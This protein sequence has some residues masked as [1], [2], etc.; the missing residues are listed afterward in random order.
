[1]NKS[2]RRTLLVAT[3]L[4]SCVVC[5][6]LQSFI[7]QYLENRKARFVSPVGS[8]N[9]LIRL[10]QSHKLHGSVLFMGSSITE[11]LLP[12]ED[13]NS[14]AMSGSCFA[15]S[16]KLLNDPEQF[17][18][19]TVYILETNNLFKGYNTKILKRTEKWDFNLFRDSSHFSLAAKPS[20]LI[21]SVIFHIL[22]QNQVKNAG[23]FETDIAQPVDF[24]NV[25]S[26]SAQELKD[27]EHLIKGVEE[28][29]A[30]GGRLCFVYLPTIQL[31]RYAHCYAPACKL[32]KHLNIPLLHYNTQSWVDKLEYTDY[33]HVNSRAASTVR[34]MNTVAR[35]ARIHAVK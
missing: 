34:F 17:A 31:E 14:I 15:S 13:I 2:R 8:E 3:A 1:M 29:R 20:N 30:R 10:Q 19:G 11:R 33:E 6:L 12:Q 18:P 9:T 16:L 26:P 28:L 27:W 32:A 4:I 5:L 25:P 35:D 23:V 24:T 21:V 7:Y 22:T